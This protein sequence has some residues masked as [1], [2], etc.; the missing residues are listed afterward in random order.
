MHL[1][2][3]SLRSVTDISQG[4]TVERPGAEYRELG[5][6]RFQAVARDLRMRLSETG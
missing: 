5:S 4:L 2:A 3:P 6:G 1:Q